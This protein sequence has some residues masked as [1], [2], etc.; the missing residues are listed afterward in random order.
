MPDKLL[1]VNNEY[2]Q[3]VR[4]LAQELAAG[5]QEPED[6]FDQLGVTQ[7]EYDKLINERVF[8]DLLGSAVAEWNAAGNT[9]KRAK[10][11]AAV[12]VENTIHHLA[13]AIENPNEPLSSKSSAFLALMKAGQ[14]GNPDPVTVGGIGNSF[15][16]EIHLSHGKTETIVIEGAHT[17]ESG[18]LEGKTQSALLEDE[19][20]KELVP[21]G[22][23]TEN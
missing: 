1:R 18:T 5:I 13:A 22:E 8:K 2:A 12:A 6:I 17:L 14:I 20:Y 4:A 19:P 21:D 10:L 11:K 15:K 16:L 9:Q 23:T 3:K 7:A